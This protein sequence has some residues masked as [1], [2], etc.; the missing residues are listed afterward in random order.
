MRNIGETAYTKPSPV[1]RIGAVDAGSARAWQIRTPPRLIRMFAPLVTGSKPLSTESRRAQKCTSARVASIRVT[2]TEFTPYKT[3]VE[4]AGE[5]IHW[6]A[7]GP[8]H[9]AAEANAAADEAMDE[10]AQKMGGRYPQGSKPLAERMRKSPRTSAS[11]GGGLFDEIGGTIV[12][13][14]DGGGDVLKSIGGALGKS[15][16]GNVLGKF[17]ETITGGVDESHHRELPHMISVAV[18]AKTQLARGRWGQHWRFPDRS[19]GTVLS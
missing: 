19:T 16:G 4:D 10:W 9:E 18:N 12:R 17:G 14:F 7:S 1:S 6:L 5:S 11:S 15:V 13:A 2:T 3:A 8:L